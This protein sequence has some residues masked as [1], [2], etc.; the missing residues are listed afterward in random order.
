MLL[1]TKLRIL[2]LSRSDHSIPSLAREFGVSPRTIGRV[3]DSGGELALNAR[4]AE[5]LAQGVDPYVVSD[6]RRSGL[7]QRGSGRS[8]VNRRKNLGYSISA[9]M[10]N[11]STSKLIVLASRAAS[12]DA[13]QPAVG[14]HGGLKRKGLDVAAKPATGLRGCR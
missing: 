10:Q 3:L 1:S 9:R 6:L 4:C 11:P 13:H 12:A 2:K 7:K 14:E 5:M 8:D